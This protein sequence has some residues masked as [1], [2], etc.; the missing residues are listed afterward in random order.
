MRRWVSISRVD[1][2][3]SIRASDDSRICSWLAA[4]CSCSATS[5]FRTSWSGS[6]GLFGVL[7]GGI[8]FSDS[9]V[10]YSCGK[11]QRLGAQALEPAFELLGEVRRTLG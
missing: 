4:A 7:A 9:V 8:T 11:G 6:A 5:D 10:G 1:R 2:F 3:A